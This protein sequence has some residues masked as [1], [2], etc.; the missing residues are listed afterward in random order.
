M[1]MSPWEAADLKNKNDVLRKKKEETKLEDLCKL[2]LRTFCWFV[3]K[4]ARHEP[5]EARNTPH[6]EDNGVGDNDACGR[7]GEVV[8]AVVIDT[9]TADNAVHRVNPHQH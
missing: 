9:L 7:L 2:G 1:L 4:P 8:L 6:Q 3:H 5:L